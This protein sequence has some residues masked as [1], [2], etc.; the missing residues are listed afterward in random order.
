MLI[1]GQELVAELDAITGQGYLIRRPLVV[2]VIRDARGE[3][4]L[5]F[6][7]WSMVHEPSSPIELL[8]GALACKPAKLHAEVEQSYI[9]Q[10]TGIAVPPTGR[11]LTE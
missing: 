6:A 4:A 1:N 7:P 5:G 10:V 8:D 11:I 2:H 3:G 9:H